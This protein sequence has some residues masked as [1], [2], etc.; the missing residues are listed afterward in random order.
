MATIDLNDKKYPK[1]LGLSDNPPPLI[2]W[3]GEW[4]DSLFDKNISI[5]GT[6]NMTRYGESMTDELVKTIVSAG[7]VPVAGLM[8]GID[9]QVHRSV[10][11]HGGRSIAVRA[12]G[13]DRKSDGETEVLMEEILQAGGLLFSPYGGDTFPA[14]GCFHSR[15][16]L[17]IGLSSLLLVVEAGISSNALKLARNCFGQD[18]PVLA[19]PGPLSS[20]QSRGTALL[21]KEGAQ[22]LTSPG[23]IPGYFGIS[24]KPGKDRPPWRDLSLIEKKIMTLIAAEPFSID[25]V[26]RKVGI[27]VFEAGSCLT[28][29]CMKD[30]LILSGGKYHKGKKYAD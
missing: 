16:K 2:Y 10:L 11:E 13:I 12:G 7:I 25:E 23:E 30:R 1:W 28:K 24:P 3:R 27:P 9:R 17:I 29:L 20:S 21:I 26:T 18:K 19:V 14:L 4:D 6:R 8:T 15:N 22:I 5:A